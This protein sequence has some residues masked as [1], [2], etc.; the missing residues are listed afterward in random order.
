MPKRQF[1]RFKKKTAKTTAAKATRAL[2]MVRSLKQQTAPEKDH[3][4]VTAS[5][6]TINAT[7][8]PSVY[9]IMTDVVQG[10]GQGERVGSEIRAQFLD[11]R[12]KLASN[13]ASL[14][15]DL[16]RLIVWKVV[17]PKGV[18]QTLSDVLQTTTISTNTMSGYTY[19]EKQAGF[20][21]IL[22]D[23]VYHL[24]NNGSSTTSNA[25]VQQHRVFIPLHN[26]KVRFLAD[27]ATVD[28]NNVYM[29]IFGS[30][31]TNLPTWD[32]WYRMQYINPQ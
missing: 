28:T 18:A 11:L 12:F 15:D 25:N 14:K 26:M 10:D 17:Q 6:V 3:I 13:I 30:N 29:T 4:D 7:T 24:R 31:G 1:R 20:F 2:A 16:I 23:K 22:H 21:K 5:T 8:A 32:Y 9:D 19:D 27:S